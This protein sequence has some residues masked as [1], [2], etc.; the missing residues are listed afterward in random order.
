MPQGGEVGGQVAVDDARRHTS[1]ELAPLLHEYSAATGAE[2]F[3]VEGM[4]CTDPEHTA[5][6]SNPLAPVNGS[7]VRNHVATK[8]LVQARTLRTRCDQMALTV[9]APSSRTTSTRRSRSA[10]V[11]RQLLIAG[12]RATRPP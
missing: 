5:W 3:T 4:G 11:L 12:R 1:G 10:A 9:F 7:Y 6:L 2:I 8:D